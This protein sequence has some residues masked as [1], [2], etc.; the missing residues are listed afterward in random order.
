MCS[1]ISWEKGERTQTVGNWHWIDLIRRSWGDGGALSRLRETFLW[2]EWCRWTGFRLYVLKN[3]FTNEES[4]C[5]VILIQAC[6]LSLTNV[7]LE[8]RSVLQT[9]FPGKWRFYRHHFKSLTFPCT[10]FWSDQ[11]LYPKNIVGIWHFHKAKLQ[12]ESL[13]GRTACWGGFQ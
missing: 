4:V 3:R 8:D 10:R 1:W 6:F 9:E 5:S 2:G 11:M 12:W 13:W 7:L